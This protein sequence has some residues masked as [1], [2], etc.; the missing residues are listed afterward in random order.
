[1]RSTPRLLFVAILIICLALMPT[2]ALAERFGT[3]T[4]LNLNLRAGPSADAEWLAT[5][6]E[7]TRV[8]ILDALDGWYEV[9]LPDGGTGFMASNYI[10]AEALAID[11]PEATPSPAPTFDPLIGGATQQFG[12][13]SVREYGDDRLT[14]TAEYPVFE[15]MQ[16]NAA[17]RRWINNTL[18]AAQQMD[19]ER[20]D[21]TIG[22]DSYWVQGRYIGVLELGDLLTATL[23][24]QTLAFALNIDT[25]TDTV[26]THQDI[27][28]EENLGA[29]LAM[30]RDALA[31]GGE[32]PVRLL[33][34]DALQ[35]TVLTNDGA[36]VLVPQVGQMQ[37]RL[38]LLPYATLIRQNLIAID[39][40]VPSVPQNENGPMI[41]LTFDDGPGIY[42]P[43]LLDI[44]AENGVKA[45]FFLVGN[46]IK[47]LRDTATRIVEEGHEIG[48]HTWSHQD[49]ETLSQSGIESQI[50]QSLSAIAT[51]TDTPVKLLRPPYG[52]Y[53]GDVRQVCRKLG[54]SI[55][56]WNIDTEDWRTNNADETYRVI[57][58]QVHE[59]CII[60]CHD[61]K[62][63]TPAAMARVIPD[64]I[65]QGYRLVTVSELLSY[66]ESG[67]QAGVVYT[68]VD[69]GN[70]E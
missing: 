10:A 58:D 69:M 47:N 42:T 33:T 13:A 53:N 30:V 11:E 70:R 16:A 55:A 68:H 18:Y 1:M 26:L 44:L 9:R 20:I 5:Y 36:A 50:S 45:T 23:E 48:T 66:S 61:I 2:A 31:Q 6:P 17:L 32:S 4:A 64:L 38:V 65:A 40:D 14:F 27:Y 19:A 43:E 22:Y 24:Q 67:G 60:L 49:L 39:I 28:G 62:E 15:S 8:Q 46:R 51:A 3:V 56:L 57:M 54:L 52:S 25:W 21:V 12:N 63:S 29:V 34:T 7:G 35:Y 37:A 41:A 59:G